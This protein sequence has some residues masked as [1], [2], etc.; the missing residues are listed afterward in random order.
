[1]QSRVNRGRAERADYERDHPSGS[2]SSGPLCFSWYIHSAVI[3]LQFRLATGIS[4]YSGNSK[5]ETWLD[6]YRVAV[7]IGGGN[8]EV[9]M[10]HLLLMLEGSAR[11]WLNQLPPSSIYCWE[12]L[13]RVFVKNFEGTYKRP[14]GLTEL[15]CYV[16]KQNETL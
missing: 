16:Q 2:S 15:Q 9:T 6:D 1:M 11:A 13:H 5:H 14:G 3:P 4:K 8:D 7:Q 10:K 12:D